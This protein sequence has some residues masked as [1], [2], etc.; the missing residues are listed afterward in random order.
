[1]AEFVPRFNW[2]KTKMQNYLR[3]DYYFDIL[4]Q[5][6][7]DM[8]TYEGLPESLDPVWIEKYLIVGGSIGIQKKDEGYIVAPVPARCGEI[9]QY[10]D[11]T[12]LAGATNNGSPLQGTIGKDCVI[13]YNRSDRLPEFDNMI[14]ASSL[15]EIDKSATINVRFSRVAPLYSCTNDTTRKALDNLLN[16]VMEGQLKTIVS[17]N[18]TDN[19]MPESGTQLLDVTEPEKIQYIQYLTQYYDAVLRRHYNRRGLQIRTG[20]KAAQ[21]SQ[22]EIFGFDAISWVLPLARLKARQ[23]GWQKFNELFDENVQV[24]F[25]DLWM[26]EYEAYLLRT[27]QRDEQKEG[28]VNA[29]AGN[30]GNVGDDRSS[31]GNDNST[32]GSPDEA[33]GQPG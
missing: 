16:D 10:G 1:M 23:D 29:E 15:M 13:I 33:D 22:S 27:L 30:P 17:D 21:Q 12:D 25:S 3:E 28:A 8:F 18:I 24:R 7:I 26:Q 32:A 31:Q 14:D 9:D 5:T 20:T 11:G 19:L 6:D 2:L 4:L